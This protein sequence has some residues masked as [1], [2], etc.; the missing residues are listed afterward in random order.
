[1]K[2][3]LSVEAAILD[4][5][6]LSE[7]TLASYEQIGM[8]AA[9]VLTGPD[10]ETLLAKHAVELEAA[11]VHRCD[12]ETAV[13][14]VNGKATLCAARK[15]EGKTIL[16]VNGKLNIDADAADTL[17]AYE[18]IVVNGKVLCPES[19]V[20]LVTEKCSVNGKLSAYPDDAVVLNGTVKLDRLFLLRA[21]ERLY[22]TDRQFVAAAPDLDAAALA[23][24]GAR[25]SAP[26]V[27]LAERFVETLLPLFNEDAEVTVLP[28]G[29]V[30]VDDD[31]ELTPKTFRRYGSKIYVMGDVNIS[32]DAAEVLGQVEYL[33]ASGDVSLSA[34]LEDVFYAIPDVEYE[35]LQ[36][37]T[38]H[39]VRN[40][41]LLNI[42]P[43]LLE[44]DPAGVT[45]A[46]CAVV[47]LDKTLTPE[48]I[49][50]K[51]R[52]NCCAI[53]R[54][55]AAQ[56]AAA[57]AVAV[58]VAQI[59]VTDAVKEEKDPDTLYRTGVELTL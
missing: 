6:H 7:E 30:L 43:E 57:A 49:V 12:D 17:R 5:R 50:A 37:L 53:V 45:C 10:T 3:N 11:L 22:W 19:L 31:F 52:L 44:L 56:E 46:N 58:N 20:G 59:K 34:A 8:Q 15:P 40:K 35:D 9:L 27:L 25:F 2:K 42:K 51:L 54:C 1:M 29:T 26:R 18:K 4:L 36:L 38:G 13:N 16:I 28:E 32:D 23:A 33:H 48:E 39:V 24:K 47:T 55:T 21:Q 14:V 41:P